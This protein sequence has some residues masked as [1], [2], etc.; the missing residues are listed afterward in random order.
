MF[1]LFVKIEFYIFSVKLGCIKKD[2]AKNKKERA[3]N[4]NTKIKYFGMVP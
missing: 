2:E 3:H 4:T 1:S